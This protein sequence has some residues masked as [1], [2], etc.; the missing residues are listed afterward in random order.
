MAPIA[1]L[2]WKQHTPSCRRKTI[3]AKKNGGKTYGT[4]VWPPRPLTRIAGCRRVERTVSCEKYVCTTA[5]HICFTWSTHT[6][7]H[8]YRYRFVDQTTVSC[9]DHHNMLYWYTGTYHVWYIRVRI[10]YWPQSSVECTNPPQHAYRS[11]GY[12]L[13]TAICNTVLQY[14]EF[15]HHIL[16]TYEQS[17]NSLSIVCQ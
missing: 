13:L 12:W 1:L 2:Y 14:K 7:R 3:F 4:I 15:I 16:D 10:D 8:I 5:V 9:E 11:Y 6:H 17:I